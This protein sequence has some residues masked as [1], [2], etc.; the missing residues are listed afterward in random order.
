MIA[1]RFCFAVTAVVLA[2]CARGGEGGF[3]PLPSAAMPLQQTAPNGPLAIHWTA[4]GPSEPAPGMPWW[5]NPASSGNSGKLNAVA[6]NGNTVFVAGGNGR[7]CE[8]VTEAGIFKSVD[9]GGTWVHANTGLTDM[10]VN[11][12]W[13]NPSDPRDLVAAT[14]RAGLF[15]S[16]NGG[17]YWTPSLR[18]VTARE[19][20]Q[21]GSGLLAA[22]SLGIYRSLDGG[23]K[24]QSMLT[25]AS[26]VNSLGAASG[27]FYA[28]DLDG[29]TYTAR[30]GV[31]RES[32]RISL[33]S[34]QMCGHGNGIRG[35]AV[36]PATPSTAYAAVNAAI[37][38]A[39]SASLWKTID[40]GRRWS[41]V[42]LPQW[43]HG[44]QA[45]AFS[46]TTRHLLYVNGN[47]SSG[48]FDGTTWH[49]EN[50]A[51][52]KVNNVFGDV[53]RLY[54]IA[55][56][57]HGERFIVA[58]DQGAWSAN[59]F[60]GAEIY[61]LTGGAL[62][63]NVMTDVAVSG[64]AIAATIQDFIGMQAQQAGAPWWYNIP[65]EDGSVAIGQGA[66]ANA[67]VV[68]D[69]VY[70]GFS[71]NRCRTF[72]TT[73]IQRFSS[74]QGKLLFDPVKPAIMY[75]IDA[76]GNV[77][78]S[79][80]AGKTLAQTPWPTA[81]RVAIDPKNDQH[82]ML[83]GGKAPV[84]YSFNAGKTWKTA[85][86]ACTD[87]RAA[88]F[89]SVDPTIAVAVCFAQSG[90]GIYRSVNGGRTFS[91]VTTPITP[92][93]RAQRSDYD[94][95]Y[96]SLISPDVPLRFNG[97][98]NVYPVPYDLAFNPTPP[99]GRVPALVLVTSLGGAVS[100][101]DGASWRSIDGDA[102][103]HAFWRVAWSNGTAYLATRGEGILTARLQ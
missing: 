69:P 56:A 57:G 67:C 4:I 70:Y 14:E 10:S 36:D 35:I 95:L 77:W 88:A 38:G 45:I 66:S 78:R 46:R 21:T 89:D 71:N 102:I 8:V 2:S 84:V 39:A 86:I 11:D 87:V 40:F 26:P 23:V 29:H 81:S 53:R 65:Y 30:S 92:D 72:T 22:T 13:M 74:A 80:N 41:S 64:P 52:S 79:N 83:A 5:W 55:G 94:R 98:T 90:A 61:S 24:W 48:T 27:V 85:S 93:L 19:L 1:R 54:V 59:S 31:W 99:A 16:Q 68:A 75:A 25:T 32:G 100:F 34:E 7:G 73:Q 101:N 58:S 18:N 9:G 49:Q 37:G 60:D 44:S 62:D 97:A 33:P 15:V 50:T 12:I 51:A 43:L 63:N 6:I 103:S 3:L 20:L 96:K 82:L 17:D 42:E 76:K 47:V 28:G 91:Y